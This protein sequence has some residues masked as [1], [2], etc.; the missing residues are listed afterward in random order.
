MTVILVDWDQDEGGYLSWQLLSHCKLVNH[1]TSLI[2]HLWKVMLRKESCKRSWFAAS[3][4]LPE[5]GEEEEEFWE[6]RSCIL[7]SPRCNPTMHT[8]YTP[9]P[10]CSWLHFWK[11][12]WCLYS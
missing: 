7:A 3:V 12:G 1:P 9:C 5:L 11:D 10:S 6:V 4:A 8:S 2:S